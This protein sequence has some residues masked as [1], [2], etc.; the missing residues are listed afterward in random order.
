MREPCKLREPCK[1]REGSYRA[2]FATKEEAEWFAS[3]PNNHATYLGDVAVLCTDCGWYHL[4][5][6]EWLRLELEPQY[7]CVK[8]KNEI[9]RSTDG[10]LEFNILANGQTCCIPCSLIVAGREIEEFAQKLNTPADINQA[11]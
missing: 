5:R 2:S 9:K 11:Y 7:F 3:D 10:S 8:C 4:D 6:S 1:T